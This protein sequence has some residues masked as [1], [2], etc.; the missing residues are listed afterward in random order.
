MNCGAW[1]GENPP[2]SA[3]CEGCGA[4]LGAVCPSWGAAASAGGRFC[5]KCGGAIGRADLKVAVG[6]LSSSLALAAFALALAGDVPHP[7]DGLSA[8][9]ISTAVSVLRDEKKVDDDTRYPHILLDEPPKA[10]VLAWR[11]GE[12]LPRRALM[13]VKQ[14]PRTFEAIVDIGKRKLDSWSEKKG[15][16]PSFLIEEILGV[17]SILKKSPEGG[18]DEEGA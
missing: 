12:E 4:K 16:Q 2:D 7:L 6:L 10:A 13:I 15:V 14:G 5:R 18:G 17:A 1:G 8:D 9:E 3:F 11:K